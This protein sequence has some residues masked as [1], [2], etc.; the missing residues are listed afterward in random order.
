[1]S[2]ISIRRH[3]IISLAHK[4]KYNIIACCSIENQIKSELWFYDELDFVAKTNCIQ[5]YPKECLYYNH[6]GVYT[7]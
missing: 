6:I 2:L 7:L 3:K 1:M 4:F 5:L